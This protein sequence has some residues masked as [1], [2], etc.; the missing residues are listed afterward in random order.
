MGSALLTDPERVRD[1]LTTL[2]QG[3]RKP[4]TCKIRLLPSR[5]DTIKLVRVIEGTGVSALAV[6]GRC[7]LYRILFGLLLPDCFVTIGTRWS[8]IQS[9]VMES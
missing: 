9:L 5:E 3:L 2:V 1:I 8:G 7:A 4:V 6:H